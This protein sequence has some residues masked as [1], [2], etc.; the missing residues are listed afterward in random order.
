[1]S[2]LSR[3]RRHHCSLTVSAPTGVE[4]TSP[5]YAKADI[6]QIRLATTIRNKR[7]SSGN[8]IR[9]CSDPTKYAVMR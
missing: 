8:C 7:V 6:D 4:N 5:Q 1:M 3:L 9:V 2:K